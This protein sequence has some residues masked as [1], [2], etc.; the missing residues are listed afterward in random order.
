MF[1]LGKNKRKT[2]CFIL[3]F[4]V[5]YAQDKTKDEAPISEAE[6]FLQETQA[7]SVTTTEETSYN[8][9][10]TPQQRFEENPKYNVHEYNYKQQVI[11][12]GTIMFCIA[13][14]LIANNNYNPKR[15]K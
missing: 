5:V 13:L 1:D 9:D 2:L 12:G 4:S 10:L 11:V 14:S 15:G 3:A 8:S 7:N 6:A